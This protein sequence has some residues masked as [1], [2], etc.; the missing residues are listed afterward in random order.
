MGKNCM[1][2]LLIFLVFP[3][4]TVFGQIQ[5]VV[6]IDGKL[7]YPSAS[8]FKTSNDIA[9]DSDVV[10][11]ADILGIR[12]FIDTTPSIDVTSPFISKSKTASLTKPYYE[13]SNGIRTATTSS[14]GG[15]LPTTIT[16]YAYQ[17]N[18]RKWTDCEIKA[19]R[20]SDGELV[21]WISTQQGATTT[22]YANHSARD[23]N[24]KI[25][26]TLAGSGN[27]GRNWI[28]RNDATSNS[29]Y[30][31][32]LT[33]TN[34]SV[35]IGGI[36]IEPDLTNPLVAEIFA[37]PELY[38]FIYIKIDPSGIEKNSDNVPI[39]RP[40]NPILIFKL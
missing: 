29:N 34:S 38:D 9:S 22:D 10:K 19:I 18:I 21:Y 27:D 33:R 3:L 35:V 7:Q 14:S 32:A 2:K 20:K 36:V 8:A 5:P 12:F 11:K 15:N 6:D 16:Y 39:W 28:E 30:A 17:P 23:K 4:I 26:Y 13:N 31:H 24:A 40:I 37:H 1:K 25:F